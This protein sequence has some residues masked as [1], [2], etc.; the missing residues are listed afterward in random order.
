MMLVPVFGLI[1]AGAAFVVM[2]AFWTASLALIAER[3]IGLRLDIAASVAILRQNPMSF[4]N[5]IGGA[6]A[7]ARN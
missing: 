5:F 3:K 1:G 4:A 2:T 7:R 6:A